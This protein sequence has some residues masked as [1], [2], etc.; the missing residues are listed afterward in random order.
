MRILAYMTHPSDFHLL[1]GTLSV[2]EKKGHSVKIFGR[3]KGDL[4]ELLETSPFNFHII[5]NNFRKDSLFHAGMWLIEKDIKM[6][7]HTFKYKPDIL[8]GNCINITH[9]SKIFQIPSILI[10]DDDNIP[11]LMKASILSLPFASVIMTPQSTDMGKYYYKQIK[12]L[13]FKEL[14]YLH[15]N[16]FQP[17]I[18]LIKHTIDISKPFYIIRLVKLNAHHDQ[19]KTGI[20]NDVVDQ[21]INLLSPHGNIYITSEKSLESRYEKFR[22]QLRPEEIH[23]ALYYSDLYIGDSQTMAAEAAVLGTPSVR[24]ND[25]VG[26]LGYLEELEH[27]YGLTKGIITTEPKIMI[28]HIRHILN[29]KNYKSVLLTRKKRMLSKK[30]DVTPFFV[31]FI[32]EYPESMHIMQRDPNYQRRYIT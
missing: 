31:W 13:G 7:Y 26:K 5:S 17:N 11:S 18:N 28:D 8:V 23:H 3:H 16:R 1:K 22:I 20:T 9:M 15:P 21:I 24:F 32:E 27:S 19:G 14:A 29:D 10:R 12:Y 2:L 25:F 6:I 30:I 4:V